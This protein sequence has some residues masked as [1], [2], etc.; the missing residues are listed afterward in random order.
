MKQYIYLLIL[1]F[2]PL[3]HGVS[4]NECVSSSQ[5]LVIQNSGIDKNTCS[6]KGIP[7][8]GKVKVVEHFADF[9]VSIVNSFPDID[10]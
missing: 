3:F 10:V 6:C 4:G 9:K 7:L 8:N 1:I 2:I 5:Y